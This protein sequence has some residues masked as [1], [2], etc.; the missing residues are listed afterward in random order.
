MG[1]QNLSKYKKYRVKRTWYFRPYVPGEDTSKIDLSLF[2]PP[3][4]GCMVGLDIKTG[5]QFLIS[6]DL[7]EK[8]EEVP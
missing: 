2:Q 1:E 5:E 3:Y 8:Y 7:F 6:K 4:T